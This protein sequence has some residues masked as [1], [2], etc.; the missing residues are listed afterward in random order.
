MEFTYL[1][2]GH[3]SL[4]YANPQEISFCGFKVD[5]SVLQPVRLMMSLGR[6]TKKNPQRKQDKK[7]SH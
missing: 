3:C 5:K 2:Q 1:E 4:I 7:C 6:L